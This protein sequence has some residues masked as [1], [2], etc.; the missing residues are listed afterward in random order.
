MKEKKPFWDKEEDIGFVSVEAWD[1]LIYK[2]W[3]EGTPE[4][5][6]EVADILAKVDLK[7]HFIYQ[8]DSDIAMIY[9]IN[10]I[11][12]VK[13]TCFF[14]ICSGLGFFVT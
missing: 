5:I 4:T 8:T 12:K 3:N 13:K 2:V 10:N 9:I 7:A 14:W 6:Q 11:V 1:G